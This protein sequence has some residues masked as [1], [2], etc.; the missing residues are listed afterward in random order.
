[1]RGF[2]QPQTRLFSFL[3]TEDRVPAQHPLREIRT[4][5]AK[6]LEDLQPRLDACYAKTSRSAV[7]AEQVLRGLLLWSLYGVP[8]EMRLLE[9]LEYNLLYRW[10]VGFE[11]EDAVWARS[12]FRDNKERLIEAGIVGEFLARTLSETP[13][14]LLLH[15]FFA[16]SLALV[17]EWGGQLDLEW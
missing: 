2:D 7:P 10:F 4:V 5:S 16:L 13:R 9:E 6:V 3:Q 12:T 11:L 17:E 8:S 1:M 14:R 15:P